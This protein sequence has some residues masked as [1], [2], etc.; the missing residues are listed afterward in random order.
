MHV[1]VHLS[2]KIKIVNYCKTQTRVNIPP[3][4]NVYSIYTLCVYVEH[5]CSIVPWYT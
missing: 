4:G 1:I 3:R 5:P 2:C